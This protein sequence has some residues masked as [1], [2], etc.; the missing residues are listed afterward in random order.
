MTGSE[1]AAGAPSVDAMTD[2]DRNHPSAGRALA[3]TLLVL[4][5]IANLALSIYGG[6]PVLHAVVGVATLLCLVALVLPY[7]RRKR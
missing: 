2:I 5:T 4:C 6:A 7:V 1:P 3:W